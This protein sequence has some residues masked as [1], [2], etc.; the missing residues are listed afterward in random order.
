MDPRA[1]IPRTGVLR[2]P[3]SGSPAAWRAGLFAAVVAVSV[4]AAVAGP[5]GRSFDVGDGPSAIVTG[6]FNADGIPDVAVVDSPAYPDNAQDGRVSVFL[7]FGNGILRP[8][9]RFPAGRTPVALEAADLDADGR[10]DLAVVNHDS[11]DVSVLLGRTDGRF[12][13]FGRFAA[14]DHPGALAIADFDRD[15]RLD[16][17]VASQFDGSFVLLPGLGKGGF[18]PPRMS[19]CLFTPHTFVA[20]D[21]DGDG[22]LDLAFTSGFPLRHSFMRGTG[23]GTFGAPTTLALTPDGFIAGSAD[24]DRDGR[25]DLVK[26]SDQAIEFFAG[27]GDGTFAA[28]IAS[29]SCEIP[30]A[31]EVA[32]LD[33]DANPDLAV[34]CLGQDELRTLRGQGDGRFALVA[35]ART[36]SFPTAVAVADLDR[37]GDQ[38][39]VTADN[40]GMQVSVLLAEADGAFPSPPRVP[41]GWSLPSDLVVRDFDGDGRA[42]LAASHYQGTADGGRIVSVR[43]GQGGASFAPPTLV[44][45][46]GAAPL[47][48]G[49]A[50]GDGI[51]DLLPSLNDP[52]KAIEIL[53]GSGTGGFSPAGPL[54]R[55][56][57]SPT[58][59]PK[60]TD[61]DGDGIGDLVCTTLA[62]AEVHLGLG[63]G[64]FRQ[65]TTMA[66]GAGPEE[67]VVEDFNADGIPDLAIANG[68]VSILH[69]ADS[70]R[71][72]DDP[73]ADFISGSVSIL[74]G[75]GNGTYLPAMNYVFGR[76]ARTLAA[77]DFDRD[78]ILDLVAD[79]LQLEVQVMKGRGD[80]TFEVLP[81]DRSAGA[82]D[83]STGDFD[84]DGR[85]DVAVLG[86]S[87][88]GVSLLYGHGDGHFRPPLRLQGGGQNPVAMDSA[89]FD[90][91]GRPD[92]ALMNI[93]TDDVSILTGL[94]AL[95]ADADGV[96]DAQDPCTDIDDDG[97]GD[98]GLGEN[99]CGAD[100]CPLVANATQAD[101]DRDGIGDACDIC[102]HRVGDDP[103][104]RDGDQTGDLCD[105]C[106]TIANADQADRDRDGVGDACDV[107]PDTKDRKQADANGDGSGDACQ[108]TISMT[109][110]N[111]DQ[112]TLK[113]RVRLRDPENDPL[114]GRLRL[115]ADPSGDVALGEAWATPDCSQGYEPFGVSGE[116]IGYSYQVFGVPVLIDLGAVL[117][118]GAQPGA[119]DFHLAI[120]ACDV[121]RTDFVPILELYGWPLPV[122]VCARRTTGAHE[123]FTLTV[124]AWD[125]DSLR[126]VSHLPRVTLLDL[127]WSGRPPRETAIEGL[128]TG[129]SARLSLTASDGRTVPV[130]AEA[131]F[132]SD[133]ETVLQSD[134]AATPRSSGFPARK[135]SSRVPAGL[136]P[137][138]GAQ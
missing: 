88:N 41:T 7:G 95:D 1:S 20:A 85:L 35:T 56:A 77:G 60:V 38:D 49:D 128:G 104:D 39:V 92:L 87:S 33:G 90:H 82:S 2:L 109:L 31:L 111:G 25:L 37:D 98:P 72:A 126:G 114:A 69:P 26:L 27:R 45:T 102:P 107:C 127:P 121:P 24:F 91:D 94:P 22:I 105:N 75:K 129:W 133:G 19:P 73:G 17:L 13:L 96:P 84:G 138:S 47:G 32:R 70:E 5:V 68:G 30:S 101:A 12:T 80:G 6:D 113:A 120:G 4:V 89:D 43:L 112:G 40:E 11:S 134:T 130:G 124:S 48:S 64:T 83:L 3:A 65:A 74:I 15:G 100:N 71:A 116:G 16:V 55:F 108:P 117:G 115:V 131:A 63:G 34:T 103:R 123:Q 135:R 36:G 52:I 9:L 125:E 23:D 78:G 93:S 110:S 50:D 59:G 81:A 106:V 79:N 29:A 132:L 136:S 14:G 99:A 118:C 122:E 42:D 54:V 66:T 53:K 61:L 76:G 67:S 57:E 46:Q 51:L 28:G 21:F 58:S 62:G 18:G 119:A 86:A 10:P 8:P 97:V 137:G 44:P